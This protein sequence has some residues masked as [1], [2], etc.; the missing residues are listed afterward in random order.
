MRQASGKEGAE[1]GRWIVLFDSIHYV[2][3]AERVFKERGVSC[4]LVPVPRSLSSDCGTAIEFRGSDLA[5]L[6]D[7]LAD[8][9]AKPQA[10]YRL[11]DAG[12]EAVP[13]PEDGGGD[14]P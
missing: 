5:A 10:V 9:R 7:V 1:E 6:R 11:S 2:L 12:Y 3:A 8:P 4:G 13:L 14:R